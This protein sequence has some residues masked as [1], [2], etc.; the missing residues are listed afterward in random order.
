MESANEYKGKYNLIKG[1]IVASLERLR[2]LGFF[3]DYP[4]LTSGELFEKKRGEL[5]VRVYAT[6]A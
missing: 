2:K 4:N 5:G 6:I 1:H 3:E